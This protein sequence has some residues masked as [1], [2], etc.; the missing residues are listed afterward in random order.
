MESANRPGTQNANCPL[1]V[2]S[3]A[4]SVPVCV[5]CVTATEHCKTVLIRYFRSHCGGSRDV[6]CVLMSTILLV[7][8]FYRFPMFLFFSCD[9]VFSLLF[10]SSLY[11]FL[12]P[13][14][15]FSFYCLYTVFCLAA[16]VPLP[17][18]LPTILYWRNLAVLLLQGIKYSYSLTR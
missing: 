8:I 9:L 14:Y 12:F 18:R 16:T 1:R 17:A 2:P 4:A 7:S 6:F 10:S 15:F 13:F 11:S 3:L 5:S